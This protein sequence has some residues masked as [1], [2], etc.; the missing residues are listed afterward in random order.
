M[1]T[2]IK[3]VEVLESERILGEGA[4]SEVVKVRHK[5]DGNEYALKQVIL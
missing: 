2:T 4:F 3:D 5:A 1:L